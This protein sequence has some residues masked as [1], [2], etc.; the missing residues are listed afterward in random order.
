MD[1][2][3]ISEKTEGSLAKRPG[4]PGMFRSELLDLD[5]VA[6]IRSALDLI[7]TAGLRSDGSRATRARSSGKGRRS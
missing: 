5:P 4:R 7:V 2:G 1:C 3:F 6:Q